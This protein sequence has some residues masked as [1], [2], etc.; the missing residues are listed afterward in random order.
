MYMHIR[1]GASADTVCQDGLRYGPFFIAGDSSSPTV[2]P[3][4]TTAEP[5]SVN[6]INAGSFAICFQVV[7]ETDALMHIGDTTVDGKQCSQP[8]A[9]MNGTWTGTYTCIN[10]GSDHDIDQPITLTITQVGNRA[11]YFDGSD[12]YEGTVCGNVFKFNRTSP[13][14]FSTESGTFV[15]NNNGSGT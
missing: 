14:D 3:P 2:D 4:S 11:Q 7:S 15:L 9:D 5:S 8:P 10:Q 13:I 1:I 12:T 6:I